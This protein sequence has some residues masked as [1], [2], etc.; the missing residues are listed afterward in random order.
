MIAY[1]PSRKGGNIP[2]LVIDTAMGRHPDGFGVAWREGGSLQVAKFGPQERI[3]FRTQLREIDK[4]GHEYVTH[5]R[6]ATHGAKDTAHSH[7]YEYMD[8]DPTV[9][10]VL[11]FHNGIV[12]IKTHGDESDTEVFV[13]DVLPSLPSRWWTVPALRY[14]V[15]GSIGWSRLVLMTAD[16]TISL[17]EKDGTWDGGLWYSSDHKP[18][19]ASWASAASRP[20][21][22]SAAESALLLLPGDKPGTTVTGR[23]H[24]PTRSERRKARRDAMRTRVVDDVR[25]AYDSGHAMTYMADVDL[26][27]E[28]TYKNA[29][30]CDTCYTTG[31]VYVIDGKP[32]FDIPHRYN[33]SGEIFEGD[34]ADHD[35]DDE[36]EAVLRRLRDY[37]DEADEAEQR[38]IA[39]AAY[40]TDKVH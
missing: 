31:D 39:D 16:E 14:L 4:A 20:V 21:D 34:A 15:N 32:W 27:L 38:L 28:M 35:D 13:R 11:V 22:K 36:E 30:V 1:R 25:K 9:G 24:K 10:R 29:I 19:S 18:S 26:S 33:T 5:F 23:L 40:V 12:N 3:A 17:H 37:A 8:P 7:P 2:Q 6:F